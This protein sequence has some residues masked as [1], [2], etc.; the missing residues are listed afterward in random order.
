MPITARRLFRAKDQK[1]VGLANAG[2]RLK[3]RIFYKQS[4]QL[5]KHQFIIGF[6][7]ETE[8]LDKHAMDK[9][10]RKNCDFIVANDVTQE[11]AGFSGDTN[12]VRYL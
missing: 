12:V 11:G 2:A 8:R 4:V 5:K 10:N 7:A 6:A 1:E 3:I 9:L